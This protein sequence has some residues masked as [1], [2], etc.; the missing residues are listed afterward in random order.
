MGTRNPTTHTTI[1]TAAVIGPLDERDRT[2]KNDY[3]GTMRFR[4]SAVSRAIARCA[5]ALLFMICAACSRPDAD[6]EAAIKGQLAKD[7]ATAPLELAVEVRNGVVTLAGKTRNAGE[8]TRAIEIARSIEGVKDV[9]N[10]MTI[11]DGPLVEAVKKALAADPMVGSI[12]I[13]V[14]S[15]NGV[16]SL[17]SDQTNRDQRERAVA[18]A[19]SVDGVKGVEDRMR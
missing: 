11:S 2:G 14:E 4:S 12:P 13:D 1:A 15:T 9:T 19:R 17:M 8:Q 16:V 7:R 6:V 5:I 3:Y 18:I 10:Q